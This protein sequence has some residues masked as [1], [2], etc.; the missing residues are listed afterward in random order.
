MAKGFGRYIRKDPPRINELKKR[1]KR[2]TDSESIMMEILDVFRE[3]EFI[4]KIGR[5]YTFVYIPKTKNLRFDQFP[6]IACIDIQKWG[7]R[8]FNFHWNEVRNYTWIEVAGKLHIVQED[9]IDYMKKVP[10]ARFLTK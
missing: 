9:E 7:F 2:L 1:I 5:Y 3:A 4:P 6:L 8:G 10:Y